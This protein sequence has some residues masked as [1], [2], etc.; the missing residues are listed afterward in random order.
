MDSNY[1]PR[2]QQQTSAY[3]QLIVK[4]ATSRRLVAGF[5]VCQ[6]AIWAVDRWR[7]PS[8]W[9]TGANSRVFIIYVAEPLVGTRHLFA[10]PTTA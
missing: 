10:D 5:G 7:E 3:Q 8:L 1:H 9:I 2:D 6:I 4:H